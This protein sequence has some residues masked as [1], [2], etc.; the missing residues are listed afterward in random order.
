MHTHNY[1]LSIVLLCLLSFLPFVV[2]NVDF[3]EQYCSKR[4]FLE[5]GVSNTGILRRI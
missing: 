2:G 5:L 3:I 4:T 1:G